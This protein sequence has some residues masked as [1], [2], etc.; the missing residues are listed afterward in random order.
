MSVL[1]EKITVDENAVLAEILDFDGFVLG[2]ETNAK[3]ATTYCVF[4][5]ELDVAFDA[6]A[7]T[8]E[9]DQRLGH[10]VLPAWADQLGVGALVALLHGG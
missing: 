3:V 10:V 1:L 6:F 2:G 9:S 8:A 7:A 4:I 5:G